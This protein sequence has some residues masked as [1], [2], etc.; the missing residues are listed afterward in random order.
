M[1]LRSMLSVTEVDSLKQ[2]LY[3]LELDYQLLTP[4]MIGDLQQKLIQ[5][6]GNTYDRIAATSFTA[7]SMT[8][9]NIIQPLIDLVLLT[10]KAYRLCVFAKE[11]HP[12]ATVRQASVISSKALSTFKIDCD[13]RVDVFQVL[14]A[15]ENSFYPMEKNQLNLEQNRFFHK[16]MKEYYRNGLAVADEQQ[17]TR[18]IAIKKE[19]SDLC[20]QFSN[21]LSKENTSFVF[22]KD[23][24]DGMPD[25]WFKANKSIGDDQYKLSLKYPDY[26]PAM[27]QLKNRSIRKQLYSAFHSRCVNENIPLL[28]RLLLLRQEHAELL[29]FATHADYMAENRMAKTKQAIREFLDDML[30]RYQPSFTTF[31]HELSEFAKKYEDDSDFVLQRYDLLYFNRL[32]LED[33][34]KLNMEAFNSYFELSQVVKGTFTIYQKMLGLRFVESEIKNAWHEDV[35][36]FDVYDH[37]DNK[38]IGS[39]YLDLYAR[40][41][42]YG[43]AAVFP[44]VSG[45]DIAHLNVTANRELPLI[46]MV[47]NFPKGK[48]LSFQTDVIMFFHEFGHAM[49]FI[50]SKTLLPMF[51]GLKTNDFAEVPSQMLENWCYEPEVLKLLSAHPITKEPLP[52]EWIATIKQIRTAKEI[53]ESMR[54]LSLSHFDFLIHSLTAEEQLSLDIKSCYQTIQQQVSAL[55]LVEDECFAASFNH[56]VSGYDVGYF[57]YMMTN[58]YAVDM[59]ATKFKQDPF[60]AEIGAQY[61]QQVL[62]PGATLDGID[63]LKNFLGRSPSNQAYVEFYAIGATS[64]R[65]DRVNFSFFSSSVQELKTEVSSPFQMTKS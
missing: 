63:L 18:I 29:G 61:R 15:Y 26:V 23:E 37:Q 35:R 31:L 14:Q 6:I 46:A 28:K 30:F 10:S 25:S 54:Q 13:Q 59:F 4:E 52:A 45:A 21:N 41:G 65:S 5:L 64:Q 16:Q 60:S 2:Y 7:E 20:I 48:H 49:H 24:L 42:K 50:C 9:A 3:S 36:F 39:F 51:D 27:N 53:I 58:V 56:L 43:H 40:D 11:I 62:A 34:C 55:P 1:A 44:L 47:C 22:A 12:N 33:N 32:M 57:G 17:K 38:K 19:I 8:Y